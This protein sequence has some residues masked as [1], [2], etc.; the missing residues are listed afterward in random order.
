MEEILT[1]LKEISDEVGNRVHFVSAVKKEN[2]IKVKFHLYT[3]DNIYTI[4]A[5]KHEVVRDLEEPAE[6]PVVEYPRSKCFIRENYLGCVVSSRKPRAGEDW[7]RGN[8]LSDG[9]Y[10]YETWTKIK[11]AI[12]KYELVKIAKTA[13]SG[14]QIKNCDCCLSLECVGCSE[15]SQHNRLLQVGR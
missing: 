9:P 14:L 1:W 5:L 4:V 7:T 2:Q 8:D 3:H 15:E 13:R 11:N 10:T 6:D 12:I